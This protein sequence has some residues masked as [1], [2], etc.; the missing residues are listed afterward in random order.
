MKPKAVLLSDVHFSVKTL[1]LASAALRAALQKALDLGVPLIIC[2]D[3]N[4]TKAIL[5]GEVVNAILDLLKEF[6][7][8][9][10]FILVGNH[11]M[12]NQKGQAHSLNFLRPFAVV[13]DEMC[14]IAQL[15]VTMI[16]YQ[17]DPETLRGLLSRVDP[18]STI[19]MHQG[20]Q[21]AEMGEYVV[22]KSSIE[23]EAL[24]PFRVISGHY[25][26]HQ[27]INCDG[28]KHTS[29]GEA[30]QAEYVGTPFSITFAEANDGAKGIQ[31]LNSDGTLTHVPLG[32]R[33]HVIRECRFEDVM[34][35]IDVRPEDLL[36][37]KVAGPASELDKLK[38]KTVGLALTGHENFKFDRIYDEAE[39]SEPQDLG[40]PPDVVF[41]KLIDSS[42]ETT[43]QK[44]ALKALWREVC[45]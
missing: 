39:K 44:T 15:D 13:I 22:D 19:I 34:S 40:L 12:L 10:V 8:V 7:E 23:P 5:R 43:E 38:K 2:G 45:S 11:D 21:G 35:P 6:S 24:A 41:D 14:D 16:P 31:I 30:G 37:V 27:I 18:G 36:W 1:A 17:D 32:L 28:K 29:H 26:K 9:E 3:L 33:R 25:H 20:I 42:E 4:D